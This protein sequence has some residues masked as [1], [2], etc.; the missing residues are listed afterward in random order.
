MDKK[1]AA[2]LFAAFILV[3]ALGAFIVLTQRPARA[4]L[5]FSLESDLPDPSAHLRH[6]FA[7]ANPRNVLEV[8]ETYTLMFTVLNEGGQSADYRLIV[9]SGLLSK[10]EI[11]RLDPEAEKT[12]SFELIPAESDKWE[13][14]GRDTQTRFQVIDL[15]EDSFIADR[16]SFDKSIVVG[17]LL[18]AYVYAPVISGMPVFG[19][20][21]NLNV[22]LDELREKPYVKRSVS[23]DNETYSMTE[24]ENWL[25]LSVSDDA[26]IYNYISTRTTF[27]SPDQLMRISVHKIDEPP[28][29]MR[30]LGD[31]TTLSY[32]ATGIESASIGFVYRIR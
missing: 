31:N 1:I 8:G 20:V 28:P 7:D 23:K 14:V 19:D 15:V 6:G 27:T 11:F 2:A 10:D 25:E 18:T 26:L 3:A 9:D 4:R 32:S 13:F 24:S 30:P 22:T 16:I 12:F 21:L 17:D 29:S 5:Y